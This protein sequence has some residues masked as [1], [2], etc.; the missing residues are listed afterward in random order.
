[1][2]CIELRGGAHTAQRQRPMQIFIGFCKYFISV[3]ICLGVGQC[4]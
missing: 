3:C 1:M 4:K 2:D